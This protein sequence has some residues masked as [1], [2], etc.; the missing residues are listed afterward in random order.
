RRPAAPTRSPPQRPADRLVEAGSVS[1]C[2]RAA[3]RYTGDANDEFA[4]FGLTMRLQ[5]YAAIAS[6]F[7]V[8]YLSRAIIRGISPRRM[9]GGMYRVCIAFAVFLV[10]ACAGDRPV[11]TSGLQFEPW[12]A[13]SE[14]YRLRPG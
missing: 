4:S 2:R 10:A 5:Q 12:S 7:R 11:Q 9:W 6:K 3:S 1:S 14:E 13:E 8:Y